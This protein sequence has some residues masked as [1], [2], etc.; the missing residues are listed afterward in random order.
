MPAIENDSL[1]PQTLDKH[2]RTICR[3]DLV[4][5][6]EGLAA[7]V[8]Q[9]S[10]IVRLPKGHVLITHGEDADEVFFLLHGSVRVLI[11]SKYIDSRRAPE[12]VGEMAAMKPGEARSAD[13][14]VDSDNFEARI[15]SAHE[16]RGI[17]SR[18]ASFRNRL[19]NLVDEVGRKNIRLLGKNTKKRGLSW[20]AISAIAGVLTGVVACI[21]IWTMQLNP[22]YFLG[23]LALAIVVFVGVLMANP[24]MRYRN[25]AT[26]AGVGLIALALYGSASFALTIDGQEIDLPLIDFSVQTELKMGVF[27]ISALALLLL[28]YFAGVLDLKLTKAQGEK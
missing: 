16:F 28:T 19:T 6:D 2:L 17:L 24:D 25:L 22:Y 7:N 1:T 23:G 21:G 9:Q 13:V 26:T 3:N 27:A 18:N 8:V 4:A 14:I 15:M 11:N 20:V 12:I 5:N 10:K